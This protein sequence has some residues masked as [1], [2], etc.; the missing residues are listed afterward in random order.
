MEYYRST[1]GFTCNASGAGKEQTVPSTGHWAAI[2]V[3]AYATDTSGIWQTGEAGHPYLQ[4]AA[5]AVMGPV[6]LQPGQ[7][8]VTQI[9]GATAGVDTTIEYR[10]WFSDV[11]DGSDLTGIIGTEI[12][13]GSITL[14]TPVPVSDGGLAGSVAQH[15]SQ[16]SLVATAPLAVGA[17][18]T[19]QTGMNTANPYPQNAASWQVYINGLQGV[20]HGCRLAWSSYDASGNPIGYRQ[21]DSQSTITYDLI[22]GSGIL[23]APT[24]YFAVQLGPSVPTGCTISIYTTALI[25][26]DNWYDAA[27]YENT[28]A[29]AAG[30]IGYDGIL[31]SYGATLGA[32]ASATYALPTY[33]GP[34]QLGV[35]L[36][37]AGHLAIVESS[38][39]GSLISNY[40][41]IPVSASGLS[42]QIFPIFLAGMSNSITVFND[43]AGGNNSFFL[44]IRAIKDLLD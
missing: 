27:I 32:S 29:A 4:N 1:G 3:T 25:I 15:L 18:T 8:M 21:R 7:P 11:G 26:Q 43:D 14:P 20:A 33:R 24:M 35:E 5:S 39:T 17:T 16:F 40:T 10:G 9:S 6:V 34:A 23:D 44:E 22:V 28:V 13:S 37:Q 38:H 19:V 36:T 41:N 30:S 42:Q 31:I 12:T 2:W